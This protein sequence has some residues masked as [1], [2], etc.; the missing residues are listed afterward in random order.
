MET[1]L[2]DRVTLYCCPLRIQCAVLKMFQ[3][4]LGNESVGQPGVSD[5]YSASR[6]AWSYFW[7]SS[8]NNLLSDVFVAFPLL[9]Q[10]PWARELIEVF[11]LASGSSSW[12]YNGVG[13]HDSRWLD[14][15]GERSHLQPQAG[16]RAK[17]LE[18]GRDYEPSSP[19]GQTSS[20]KAAPLRN[21]T[22]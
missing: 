9:W 7:I 11:I 17:E 4:H 6:V 21:L 8:F 16:S 5:P 22:Q 18:V 15:E 20:S 2:C 19:W 14:R 3:V 1:S 12:V 10:T 13:R